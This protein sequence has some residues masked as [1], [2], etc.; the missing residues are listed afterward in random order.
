PGLAVQADDEQA[1]LAVPAQGGGEVGG[2]GDRHGGERARGG[3]P[4]GGGDPGRA[5]GRD[6]QAVRAEGGRGA[7]DGSEVARVGDTVEGDDQ[8]LLTGPARGGDQVL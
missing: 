8:R 7:G 5:T 2:P 3:L 6:E 4:R 1:R